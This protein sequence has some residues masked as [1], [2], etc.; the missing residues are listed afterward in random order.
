MKRDTTLTI[1]SLDSAYNF[2][3]EGMVPCPDIS[4]EQT[5]I[6]FDEVNTVNMSQFDIDYDIDIVI[7]EAQYYFDG[8]KTAEQAT[9]IIQDRVQLYMDEIE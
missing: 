8:Q 9:A 2:V 6:M 5:G 1:Y 3:D 4:K 7:E